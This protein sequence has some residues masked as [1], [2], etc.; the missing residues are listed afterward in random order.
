MGKLAK[1]S[2]QRIYT[3][4]HLYWLVGMY[5]GEGCFYINPEGRP[6]CNISSCDYDIIEKIQEITRANAKISHT[7]RHDPNH[8]DKFQMTLSAVDSVILMKTLLPYMG[9]RR[10]YKI[11]D[12]LMKCKP[13]YHLEM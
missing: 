13:I 2:I 6:S 7:V 9:Q 3:D 8:K 10:R 12:I 11:Y 4:S 1:P 5:E